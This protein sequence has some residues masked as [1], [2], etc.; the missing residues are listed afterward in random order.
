M[1]WI[2]NEAA[3]PPENPWSFEWGCPNSFAGVHPGHYPGYQG[4]KT[5]ICHGYKPPAAAAH[6]TGAES[7]TSTDM[8]PINQTPTVPTFC[9]ADDFPQALIDHGKAGDDLLMRY[10]DKHKTFAGQRFI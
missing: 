3:V 10:Y 5:G 2:F 7:S 8:G 1:S 9:T 4:K 6:S